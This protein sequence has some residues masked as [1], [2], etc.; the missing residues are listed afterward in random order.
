MA[1]LVPA[2]CFVAGLLLGWLGA[3]ISRRRPT[4]SN[5]LAG[6]WLPFHRRHSMRH[7][8][9]ERQRVRLQRQYRSSLHSFR[10]SPYGRWED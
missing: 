6:L 5:Q 2:G 3:C 8:P 1:T 10:F 9:Y 4:L 7:K